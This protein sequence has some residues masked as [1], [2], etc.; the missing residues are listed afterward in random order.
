MSPSAEVTALHVL[1][2]NSTL[3]THLM[4]LR[5]TVASQAD[6]ILALYAGNNAEAQQDKS[7][8][9]LAH[10]LALRRHDL[11]G[12]QD[13]LA[14]AGASSL[15]RCEG[16]V[17]ATLDQVI[18]VLR[19]GYLE[20]DTAQAPPAAYPS[21]AE[22]RSLLEFNTLQLFGPGDERHKSRIM[23][24]LPSEAS[25]DQQLVQD[26]VQGGM[27]CAR[28]NCAHD[29]PPVW[30][31]MV[32]NVVRARE[33][34]GKHCVILMDL[35]GQK[36]RTQLIYA[37][38]PV[39]KLK[40]GADAEDT[41]TS[42]LMLIESSALV[43]PNHP[44][45]DAPANDQATLY[46]VLPARIH[47]K[48]RV[49]DRLEFNDCR[50]KSRVIDIIAPDQ[51]G[52][53]FGVWDKA[54]EIDESTLISWKR[55]ETDGNYVTLDEFTFDLNITKPDAIRLFHH[56]RIL[57]R[58]ENTPWL[59][60]GEP[61]SQVGCSHPE[62]IDNLSP[63]Q[64]VWF[65]DGKLGTIIEEIDA[66]G[67][68][69]RIHH[70]SPTGAKLRTDKGINCPDSHIQLPPLTGKDLSDLD[71]VC[72]YADLVG[73]SFVQ[74]RSDM[75]L[76]MHELERRHAYHLGIIAKI[77]TKTAVK[78]LPE[79]MLSTIPNYRLGV[80]IARGDLAVELG[81]E[82][83]AEIQEEL[84]WL[85]EAAHV[86]VIW[87]T[88]VLETL[89]KKGIA[90]RAELTDAAMSGRAECVMLNKGPYV[91]RGVHT[92]DAILNRM[93]DHQYKKGARLRALHW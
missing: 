73:Y 87:A 26:L 92:L 70:C 42:L 17:M 16:H 20:A 64:S 74:S 13:R 86:P 10:Y 39:L 78:N 4:A 66:A 79:I 6:Q 54:S 93:Q 71:F 57:L 19:H 14:E 34:S 46:A 30:K 41:E 51:D 11:R 72:Q 53:W 38:H 24:T 58:R 63:G 47:N 49:G 1:S 75:E 35:A 7:A 90:T 89:V 21:F 43:T 77:E 12:L 36:I 59:P 91:L 69:L 40:S 67:A 33:L 83:M 76:L 18:R 88:Q 44:A 5:S 25:G 68:W 50:G 31:A 62:I 28:I 2:S 37:A 9:N 81:G 22:G 82:R 60:L 48:L 52:R 3:L 27:N 61:V 29:S 45:T 56:D 84:L 85:C 55:R 15:G 8:R 80:M 65:D 23:V 32:E